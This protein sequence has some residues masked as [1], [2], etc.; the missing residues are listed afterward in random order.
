[1]SIGVAPGLGTLTQWIDPEAVRISDVLMARGSVPG[2]STTFVRRDRDSAIVVRVD[3]AGEL[4]PSRRMEL[5]AL[6][7]LFARPPLDGELTRGEDADGTDAI[8]VAAYIPRL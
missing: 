6:P 1:T 7:A 4:H 8:G 3:S 5:D 2:A